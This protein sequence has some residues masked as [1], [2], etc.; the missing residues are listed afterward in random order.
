MGPFLDLPVFSQYL[1][2]LFC[3]IRPFSGNSGGSV[4]P[5]A[6]SDV[7]LSVAASAFKESG[8]GEVVVFLV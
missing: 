4:W 5:A 6:K 3:F 7:V 2:L 8:V 1:Y